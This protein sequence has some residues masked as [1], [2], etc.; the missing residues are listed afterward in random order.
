MVKQ[1][2][3]PYRQENI[4]RDCYGECQD[5]KPGSFSNECWEVTCLE[6]LWFKVQ[7]LM[8]VFGEDAEPLGGTALLEEVS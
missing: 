1:I 4:T 6:T 2:H 7:V 3:I 5:T 8:A